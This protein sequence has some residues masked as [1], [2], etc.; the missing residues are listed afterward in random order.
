[1]PGA[2]VD[3]RLSSLLAV[4]DVRLTRLDVDDLLV[5]VLERLRSILH[6]DTAAVLMR[7]PGADHL[8]ARAAC[9]LEEEV[10]QGVQIPIGTGFAGWIAAR[11]KPVVLDRVDP[12]TVA[13]PILWEKGIRHMAGV[14]L[15]AGGELIGV[16]HVGRTEDRGF[17]QHD[18]ELLELAAERVASAIQARRL[19]VESAAGAVLERELLPTR[20]PSLPGIE[21]AAR[22]APAEDRSIGGDWYDAFLVPSGELWLVIGDVAGH[23]LKSA[24]MVSRVKTALRSFSLLGVDPGEVLALTNSTLMHFETNTMVTVLCA[25]AGPPFET[26]RIWSA[27]HPPPLRASSAGSALVDV[28]P[29]PPLG[30]SP[31]AVYPPTAVDLA[32]GETLLLYTD[33]L[34]ERSGEPLDVGFERLRAAVTESAPEAICRDVMLGLIGNAS[35][36][37]DVALLAVHRRAG[38]GDVASGGTGRDETYVDVLQLEPDSGSIAQARDFAERAAGDVRPD[39]QRSLRLL[40]SELATNCVQH[41]KTRF[42]IT[43]FKSADELRVECADTAGGTVARLDPTPS[44]TG[45]R[46][47][48]FVARFADEWGV[49]IADP[50]PGKTVWFALRIND[51]G[52]G[53]NALAG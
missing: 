53:R 46:G 9:G 3:D 39:T 12:T 24:V 51:A 33:G 13:N 17:N 48:Y 23:G 14:P 6:T 42:T 8:V 22:Y 5:E 31:D 28:R 50:G 44:A 41:A 26:F 27:G 47:V 21:F 2:R 29:G 37:D 36:H 4:T 11:R 10:R 32:R 30:A 34:I 38:E 40:V 7:P 49:R 19:A 43:V 45:G 1:M 25:V 20:L 15:L 52:P 18:V 35:T 16:V